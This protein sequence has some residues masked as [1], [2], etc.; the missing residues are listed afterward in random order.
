MQT[1]T[2]D[3]HQYTF[4]G[5]T[6]Y[7]PAGEALAHYEAPTVHDEYAYLIDASTGEVVH[8]WHENAL[9]NLHTM[10]GIMAYLHI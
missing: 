7:N 10:T 6:L 1:F 2:F 5:E 4:D 9:P 8:S 3:A